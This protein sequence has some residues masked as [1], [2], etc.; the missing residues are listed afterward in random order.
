MHIGEPV[1]PCPCRVPQTGVLAD[2]TVSAFSLPF[3]SR[4]GCVQ[5]MR[6]L[7]SNPTLSAITP[8]GGPVSIVSG[9][10]L[11]QKALGAEQFNQ[12]LALRRQKIFE[13]SLH[14]GNL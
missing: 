8:Q 1:A 2:F 11:D 12:W 9:L 6:R 3:V 10:K 13:R 14:S 4:I 5:R 7:G